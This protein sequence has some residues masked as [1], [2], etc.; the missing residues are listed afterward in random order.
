MFPYGCIEP[1]GG[2]K[3]QWIKMFECTKIVQLGNAEV[4]I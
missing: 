4:R 1:V 3:D 2:A